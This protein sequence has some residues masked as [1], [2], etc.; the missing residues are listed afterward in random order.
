MVESVLLYNPR[1]NGVVN[2]HAYPFVHADPCGMIKMA[3]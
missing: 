3:A 1:P 2:V